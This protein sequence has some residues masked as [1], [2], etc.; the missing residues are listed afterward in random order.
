M[1]WNKLSE[2]RKKELAKTKSVFIVGSRELSQNKIEKIISSVSKAKM[3][4]G[5]LKEP[6]ILGFE[7]CPQFET[8]KKSDLENIIDESKV[9]ILEYFE[10]DLKYILKELD[11][12]A[13]I[14]I[15]ASWERMLHL[16]EEFWIVLNKK[17]PYKLVSP[18]VD[19]EEAVTYLK[20]K[21]EK[22]KTLVK[23]RRVKSDE[24]EEKSKVQNPKSKDL[25]D[26][27]IME[28]VG[29]VAKM[30]FDHVKQ[31]G[32][33]LAKDGKIIEYA[34][35]KI[36][37]FE[38]YAMHYGSVREKNFSPLNDQNYHDTNHAEVELLI[39]AVKNKID[40]KDTSL[41]INVLPCPSCARMISSTDISEIVY[42]DDHSD[43]YG[44]DLLT[45]AGKKVRRI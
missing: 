20:N 41:Y 17:I 1:D 11:F 18:F 45:K 29:E 5:I 34:H 44:F 3:L 4:W 8:L 2:K 7:N 16:R 32:A 13:V 12:C 14:F 35:N 43:G 25:N 36:V 19:E 9:T 21:K 30:S 22:I 31:I 24:I 37:P 38:T 39:K 27:E 28:V 42:R 40:L 10:R 26:S 33:V 6:Y 23:P 15:H